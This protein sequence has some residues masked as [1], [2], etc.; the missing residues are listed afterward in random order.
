MPFPVRDE[1]I[2]LRD[3]LRI[4]RKRIWV[5]TTAALVVTGAGAL[6]TYSQTPIYQA[7]AVVQI[8]PDPPRVIGIQEVIPVSFPG[9]EYFST[10]HALVKSRVVLQKAIEM[11]NLKQRIPGMAN[12][13]DPTLVIRGAVKVEPRRGTRLAE[14]QYESTDPVL[15]A[16]I[17]N[18][19]ARAYVKN[20]LDV[21]L[22]GTQEAIAWLSEQMGDLQ[23]KVHESLISLQNFRIKAQIL[24]L[25]EQRQ[26][27]TSKIVIFNNNYLEAKANRITI[28]AKLQEMTPI[29]KDPVGAQTI[30]TVA[31]TPLIQ[32]LKTEAA[33]LEAQLVR[34]RQTYKEKHPELLKIQA[35]IPHVREKLNAA[36]QIMLR[37]VQN[38]LSV[39]K[40]R[41]EAMLRQLN[42]LKKEGTA[43]NETEIQYHAMASE[44]GSIQRMFD[45][46]LQ[47]L[48]ETTITKG[49]QTNNIRLVEAALVP[50]APTRPDK[51]AN[52]TLAG[53]SGLVLGIMVAFF[54]EYLDRTIKTPEDVKRVLDLPI[55]GVIPV[56]ERK[57]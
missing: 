47:R 16:D 23:K 1:D 31:D 14:I 56:F 13:E 46:V 28:E 44:T 53:A 32:K 51:R 35:Q 49:L 25:P 5:I 41:E 9:A 45:V 36:L 6:Y 37:A 24:G 33:D 48:K 26:I 4:L 19:I 54:L 2:H 17:A 50:N 3:Y 8:D 38:E 34:A 42:E 52:L 11:G 20:N 43:L 39:A 57:R 55:L 12:A 30:F 40:A 15:A 22:K 27:T 21:K 18:A 10:E 29:M 7:A